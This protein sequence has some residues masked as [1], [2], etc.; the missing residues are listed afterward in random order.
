[1]KELEYVLNIPDTKYI[2][3]LEEGKKYKVSIPVGVSINGKKSRKVARV[4]GT[5]AM[6]IAKR[7]EMLEDNYGNNNTANKNMTF[8][9]LCDY[10]LEKKKPNYT[11][12]NGKHIKNVKGTL[13]Y[14]S[15]KTYK[16]YIKNFLE[17]TIRTYK[18]IWHHWGYIGQIIYSIKR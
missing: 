4:N 6:A 2:E 9:E 10:F 12:S 14:G 8:S 5:L 7:N 17:P 15:I 13:S 1:M 16:T 3:T 11:F 18:S